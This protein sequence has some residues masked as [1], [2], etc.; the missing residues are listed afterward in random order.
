MSALSGA[1]VGIDN[2]NPHASS[3]LEIGTG[4]DNNGILLPRVALTAANIAAPVTNP[5]HSLLIYNTSTNLT[6]VGYINDVR[7]GFYSWDATQNKWITQ[8]NENRAAKWTSTNTNEELNEGNANE[9]NIFG[10]QVFNDDTGLYQVTPSNFADDLLITEAGRYEIK[11]TIGIEVDDNDRFEEIVIK[12][13]LKLTRLGTNTFP[14]VT[15]YGY[16]NDDGDIERGQIQIFDI[17]EI[18]DNTELSIQ[19]QRETD[20]GEVYIESVGAAYL[21]IRKIQ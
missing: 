5:A 10:T 20:D 2:D 11:T 12:T 16:I 6:P 1:Q 7:P 9:I 3:L 15:V 13:D 4:I 8:T 17:I 19:V 18:E 21:S 14:S